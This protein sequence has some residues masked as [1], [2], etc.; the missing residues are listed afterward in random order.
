MTTSSNTGSNRQ[1]ILGVRKEFLLADPEAFKGN[2]KGRTLYL[3]KLEELKPNLTPFQKEYLIGLILSDATVEFNHVEKTARVK[4]QQSK[5]HIGWLENVKRIFLEYMANDKPLSP[6]SKNRANMLE[7]QTLKCKVFY[8]FLQPIFYQNQER[9]SILH[10][11]IAH[12]I[13]PVCV[14]AWYCGDGSK[15]DYTANQGKGVTFHSQGFTQAENETLAEILKSNLGF[16]CHAKQDGLQ[17]GQ[18]RLDVSGESYE[19]FITKVGPYIDETF[20]YR[21]PSGRLDGSRF[22]DMTVTKRDNILGSA[23]KSIGIDELVESYL[24][25]F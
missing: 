6:P 5:E 15:A 12:Y 4:M 18:W 11:Q 19:F 14:A 22:G 16:K 25:S 1:E 9:K 21:V 2:K 13:G 20:Y 3:K 17:Y 7:I 8:N 10:N 24:G 23:I